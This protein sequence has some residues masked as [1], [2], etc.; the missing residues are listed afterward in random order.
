VKG[1]C[2]IWPGVELDIE[3]EGRRGHLIVIFD[4]GNAEQLSSKM[5]E[6]LDGINE[7]N[8]KI[9]IEETVQ[10]F[11]KMDPIYIAHYYTKKPDLSDHDIEKLSS[12]IRNKC[13]IIKEATNYISAGIYVCH[14]HN[15]IYGSDVADWND[16]INISKA[17]PELRLP[18]ESFR[19]FCLLLEK[20]E[21]TINTL[22]AKKRHEKINISPFG[23]E[24]SISLNIYNDINIIFGSK[25]TGKTE[26]LHAISNYYNAS[27]LKTHVYESS[28]ENLND[29]YDI[30]GTKLVVKLDD[31]GIDTCSSEIAL[32]KTAMEE[33]I[34]SISNYINHFS[35][36]ITNKIAKTISITEFSPLDSELLERKWDEINEVY[37]E[38]SGFREFIKSNEKL[39]KGIITEEHFM[40]L[41]KI[42][43]ISLDKIGLEREKRYIDLSSTKLF[44]NMIKKFREEISKKTGKPS[45]P[46]NTGFQNYASNRIKIE[47]K[48]NKIIT[49][50]Q[51]EIKSQKL[52]VGDL[53]E[54]GKL[55]CN[56]DI[57]I[58][59]GNVSDSKFKP[60]KNINKK[61]QNK[62]AK[63]IFE[64]KE[65]LYSSDL[66]EKISKLNSIEDGID[67]IKDIDDLL[68][69]HR[70]FTLNEEPYI[71]SSGES[72]MLLLHKELSEEK[73]IYLLDEP[74][75][76]LGND[77]IN[78][79][80]VPLLK[81]RAKIGK[82]IIIATHDANIAVR[83]LPYNT[84]YRKHDLNSYKTY[85]GNPFSNN[86]VNINDSKDLLN[87]KDTSMKILEGGREAFGERGNIYGGI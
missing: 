41:I 12:L 49:N 19:Q 28:V 83:T 44:N 33:S 80:I 65:N 57:V 75:K 56:T 24:E 6:L 61:P 13:R 84:I 79:V 85:I 67:D 10:F 32:I 77:Y 82:K 26:I 36:E 59:N 43:E 76:S 27:G 40:E 5:K 11:D 14:G 7:D 51:K 68:L 81:E 48:V 50:M 70:Y 46:M 86:L 47:V 55:Y 17:L 74:E 58:Q 34:T 4:P 60:L 73:D 78:D 21:P 18:V 54:K 31:I 2:Q 87:W 52:Y 25:G 38:V 9:S 22:L 15:S 23:P 3:E 30:K 53:G 69:F 8:F 29:T 1:I 42:I 63:K 64:I 66:F 72:S 45:K 35:Y 20:D 37:D 71:P 39:L 16:Y 62:F